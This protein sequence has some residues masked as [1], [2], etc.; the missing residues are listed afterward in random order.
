MKKVLFISFLFIF[1]LVQ[2]WTQRG[3][4]P[5]PGMPLIGVEAPSFTA[6]S[7]NGVINFPADFGSDWKILFAHPKNFTPVCS[8]EML[9][10]AAHQETFD[11]LGAKIVVISTDILDQH[12][13]WKAALEEI[14][15]RDNEPVKIKFPLVEDDKYRVSSQY[16]MIH[17]AVSI[18]QNIRG[19]FIIDP[20]NKVRAIFYYPNEVGRNIDELS[21]TLVALQATRSNPKILTPANW[22]AG[23]D[24]MVPVI[25]TAERESIGKPGSKLYQFSYFM[26]YQ[27]P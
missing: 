15:Y 8:S 19:V 4:D 20:D 25:T 9:E 5:A 12:Y 6:R 24:F 16:G 11:R 10:L 26:I 22:R 18:G 1:P 21:R 17:P 14:R 27:K 3:K 7:T 13:H 23:D 2:S